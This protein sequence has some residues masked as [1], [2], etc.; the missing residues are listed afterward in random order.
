[1]YSPKKPCLLLL[2]L[3]FVATAASA[4]TP[5]FAAPYRYYDFQSCTGSV[6]TGPGAQG[7][8]GCAAGK[9]RNGGVFDGIDDAV[10]DASMA[11]RIDAFTIAAWVK[12]NSTLGTQSIVSNLGSYRLAVVDQTYQLTI[13]TANGLFTVSRPLVDPWWTHVA[14]SYDGKNLIL[15]VSG[16][17]TV[18]P[19]NARLA[20]PDQA[21]VIGGSGFAGNIDEVR[22]WNLALSARQLHELASMVPRNDL[23]S[24]TSA[25][26]ADLTYVSR[27]PRLAYDANPNVPAVGSNVTWEAHLRNRGSQPLTNL[28]LQWYIDG[29]YLG[30]TNIASLAPG[31]ETT[32]SWVLPWSAADQYL[33]VYADPQN[34]ISERSERNNDRVV[35]TNALMV[36]FWVEQSV[37]DYFD[38]HQLSFLETYGLAEDEANSWEDWAERQID[39]FNLALASEAIPAGSGQRGIDRVRLDQVIVVPDGALP[40]NGGRATNHPDQNDKTVDMM[41]GFPS[42][43]DTNF[44]SLTRP[45]GAFY[46]EQGLVHELNHARFLVD[47]YALNLHRQM[48]DVENGVG[49]RI[50]PPAAGGYPVYTTSAAGGMMEGHNFQYAEWEIDWLNVYAGLRPLPGWANFNAHYGLYE[51]LHLI[52]ALPAQNRL[53]ILDASGQPL[54]G[55][56]VYMYQAVPASLPNETYPRRVDNL[57]ELVATVPASGEVTIGSN[58]FSVTDIW[59]YN[60]Q[61]CVNFLRIVYNGQEFYSGID[62]ANLQ[63]AYFRGNQSLAIHPIATPFTAGS[64]NPKDLRLEGFFPPL[65]FVDQCLDAVQNRDEWRVRNDNTPWANWLSTDI[66]YGSCGTPAGPYNQYPM[67][68]SQSVPAPARLSKCAASGHLRHSFRVLGAAGLEAPYE[69]TVSDNT[70]P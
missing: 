69:T 2:L 64:F 55:A 65:T 1:M 41:W 59:G 33:A 8:V 54:F 10:V 9:F 7:G 53:K 6:Y 61:Y 22:Q 47:S 57:P 44:Y 43:V 30:G 40:L 68:F 16:Q 20:S 15:T 12:P 35:R 26:D 28:R 50:Y 27:S 18:L 5:T 17:A 3:L 58:P 38:A 60:F 36:G 34:L 66:E 51:Y 63:V 48:V 32:S 4:S 46:T 13:T 62:L 56:T 25:Y 31:A 37:R 19:V 14:G 39:R 52:S 67:R 24:P 45:T 11:T 23:G 42:P 29:K 49:Y 70:C 21:F